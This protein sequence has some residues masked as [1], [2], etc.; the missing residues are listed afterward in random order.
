VLIFLI[1][2]LLMLLT[3]KLDWYALTQTNN[4]ETQGQQ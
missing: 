2:A 4:P 3:R 1:L